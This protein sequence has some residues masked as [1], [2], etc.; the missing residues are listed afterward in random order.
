MSTDTSLTSSA[1][2]MASNSP[3]SALARMV[4]VLAWASEIG[5]T[6]T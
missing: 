3:R 4:S 5:P 6:L 1:S 2:L